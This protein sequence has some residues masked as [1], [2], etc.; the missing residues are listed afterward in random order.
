M[1][2]QRSEDD[3]PGPHLRQGLRWGPGLPSLLAAPKHL[4]ILL[5]FF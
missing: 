5:S 1:A 4:D 3:S 2:N